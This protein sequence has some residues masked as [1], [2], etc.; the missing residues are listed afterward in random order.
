MATFGFCRESLGRHLLATSRSWEPQEPQVPA[1]SGIVQ[2]RS[3]GSSNCTAPSI[4]PWLG[5]WLRNTQ[6]SSFSQ[7][8]TRVPNGTA[9]VTICLCL[10]EVCVRA[11]FILY[12]ATLQSGQEASRCARGPDAGGESP[13]P[14]WGVPETL[15]WFAGGLIMFIPTPLPLPV[16][17]PPKTCLSFMIQYCDSPALSNLWGAVLKA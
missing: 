12:N 6:P 11:L 17:R 14:S 3:L 8:F 13:R 4:L 1:E 15:L 10:M 7:Y 16:Y 2:P 5:P 9:H